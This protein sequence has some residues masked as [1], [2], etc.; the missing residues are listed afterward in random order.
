LGSIV[1]RQSP[2]LH[3]PIP[4]LMVPMFRLVSENNRYLARKNCGFMAATSYKQ[5]AKN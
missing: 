5:C 2:E 4:K 1:G 3:T